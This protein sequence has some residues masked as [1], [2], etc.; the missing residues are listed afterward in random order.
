MTAAVATST[1]PATGVPSLPTR[2][3]TV[4]RF[5]NETGL[6]V[7]RGL[8]SLPHVP[9]RLLD[10]TLQP[11]MFTLLF[12]Y[13][14]GSAIHVPGISYQNY[15]LPG[16]IGQSLAFGVIGA[17]VATATDF[18]TGVTSRF[19]S[20]P[21]TRLSVVSAQVLGQMLEQVLG[22][23]IVAALGLALGWR[24]ELGLWSGLELIGLIGLGLFAFTWFGVLL[25]LYV[26]SPDAMQGV[27]FVVVFPL[28]FLSG[29]FVPIEGMPL[30][31]R[32]IGAWNPI[33]VLVAAVRAI[34]QGTSS[35]GS[36]QLEHPVVAMVAWCALLIAVCV[37]LAV[38]RFGRLGK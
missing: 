13:V 24:P 15:L 28:A 16:L 19:R 35:T 23:T 38:R 25:G 10:V 4:R 17:G 36:W 37:P 31:P 11:I 32:A 7:G 34:C 12:L 29:A 22:L 30:V 27:G 6:L 33:S 21:V 26:R 20:L 8:R 18:S 9:E 5:L 14:I 3:S 2:P 1:N